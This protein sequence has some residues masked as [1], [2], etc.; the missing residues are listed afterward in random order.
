[1]CEW[2]TGFAACD[3][4]RADGVPTRGLRCAKKAVAE[5]DDDNN[6]EEDTSAGDESDEA[7]HHAA[8]E[9]ATTAAADQAAEAE[10]AADGGEAADGEHGELAGERAMQEQGGLEA[11]EQEPAAGAWQLEGDDA[12][13]GND[14][15][16]QYFESGDQ[17]DEDDDDPHSV[18]LEELYDAVPDV[19]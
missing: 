8:L 12:D 3:G 2:A 19:R 10:E 18:V 13:G 6:N 4:V 1:M 7:A 17:D 14:G 9:Q 5:A 15:M 11:N 16:M